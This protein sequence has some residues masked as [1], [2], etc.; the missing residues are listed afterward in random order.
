MLVTDATIEI[1]APYGAVFF[2][3]TTKTIGVELAAGSG[4]WSFMSD[5]RRKTAFVPVDGEQLLLRMRSLPLWQWSYDSQTGIR[6]VG[7]TSQ[8]FAAAF[9]LG[10][11]ADA[12]SEVDAFG[13][14]LAAAQALLL[15]IE[16]LEHAAA[17]A[18]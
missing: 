15:R 13:V 2:T 8:D 10:E 16:R 4:S 3:N 12:I 14:G 7:P 1:A 9:G 17:T 6:H 5:A 18:P 11:S